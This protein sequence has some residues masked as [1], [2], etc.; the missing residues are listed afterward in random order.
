MEI[1]PVGDAMYVDGR[2]EGMTDMKKETGA[3]SDDANWR[4]N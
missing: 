4:K 2:T 3:V 1:G